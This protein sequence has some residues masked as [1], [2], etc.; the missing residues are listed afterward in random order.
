MEVP[1]GF[2]DVQTTRPYYRSSYVFLTR[3]DGHDAIRSF[4]D[5][6]LKRLRIGM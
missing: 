1:A 4:D 6:R 2:D 3:R 5:P